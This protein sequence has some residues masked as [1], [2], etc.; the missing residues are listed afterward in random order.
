VPQLPIFILIESTHKKV[1]SKGYEIGRKRVYINELDIITAKKTSMIKLLH[2]VQFTTCTYD[3]YE[4]DNCC[5]YGF[6]YNNRPWP[7]TCVR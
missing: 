2:Y 6:Y 4:E 3:P 1:F 5:K 7:M